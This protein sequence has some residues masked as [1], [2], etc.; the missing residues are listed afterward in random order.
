MCH[1]RETG[2]QEEREDDEIGGNRWTDR[3]EG[4]AGDDVG[5]SRGGTCYIIEEKV[6]GMGMITVGFHQV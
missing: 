5:C 2:G 1:V 4:I 6:V 3:V